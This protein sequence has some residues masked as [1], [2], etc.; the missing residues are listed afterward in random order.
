MTIKIDDIAGLAAELLEMQQ[1]APCFSQTA[2]PKNI[3]LDASDSRFCVVGHAERNGDL[4]LLIEDAESQYVFT[5][6]LDDA[7]QWAVFSECMVGSITARDVAVFVQNA[8]AAKSALRGHNPELSQH[9]SA[10]QTKI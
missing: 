10:S 1:T 5:Q 6:R 7:E 4:F 9:S 3:Q 8:Q 2:I